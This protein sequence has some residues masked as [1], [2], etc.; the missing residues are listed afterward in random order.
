[1]DLWKGVE[2]AIAEPRS[3]IVSLQ[4]KPDRIQVTI[5]DGRLRIARE[6][7]R[8]QHRIE[9]EFQDGTSEAMA[10]HRAVLDE[11]N[12]Q[13]KKKLEAAVEYLVNELS[14]MVWSKKKKARVKSIVSEMKRKKVL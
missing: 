11:A 2:E 13:A 14:D 5:I 6:Y 7:L 12:K 8:P 4:Q 3:N 1:M 10:I 9:V